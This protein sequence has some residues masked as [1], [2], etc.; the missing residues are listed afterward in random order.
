VKT[1]I[2]VIAHG[3]VDDLDD[4][5]DFL[6]AIRRGHAPPPPLLAEVRRHYEAIGGKSPLNA[7]CR[8][9]AGKLES[10]LG[11]P[12]RLAMRLW[13]PYPKE[14][15]SLLIDAGVERIVVLPLAQHSAHVYG[16]AVEAAA[17]ELGAE[18]QRVL[19]VTCAKNWG[20]EPALTR[21]YA[22][23][24]RK[25]LQ[26]T[27][28]DRRGS[29]L[30]LMTAHSLPVAAVRSGD[31]YE[32]EVR[33]SAAA[34]ERELGPG[35]PVVQVAFQSQGTGGGDWLGPN[36]PKA[37][38]AA[39]DAGTRHVLIAPVGFLA[40]HVEILYDLDIEAQALARERGMSFVRT[41]SLNASDGLLDALE[42]VARPLLVAR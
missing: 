40:D 4:L 14:V 36:L 42:N 27:P 2:I 38:D 7:I 13:K 39:R 41:R 6:T 26:E 12:V 21:A 16:D 37:L 9:V 28:Q 11:L 10:R 17:R 25:A 22:N 29:S 19:Q 33:A 5:P 23:E 34:I 8:E 1:A 3:T 24:I 18:G 32:V 35:A 15:L 30:I 31:P 20:L